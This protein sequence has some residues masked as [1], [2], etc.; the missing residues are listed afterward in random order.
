MKTGVSGHSAGNPCFV[1]SRKKPSVAKSP[2]STGSFDQLTT[3][4]SIEIDFSFLVKQQSRFTMSGR[5][6]CAMY[7]FV[8]P[9]KCLKVILLFSLLQ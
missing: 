5:D 3:T 2:F 9:A 6:D 8:V 7:I 1:T 4:L